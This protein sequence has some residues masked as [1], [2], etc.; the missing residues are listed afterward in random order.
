MKQNYL[1]YYELLGVD[2]SATT[3]QINSAYKQKAKESHPDKND[4]HH[5]AKTLFQYYSEAKEVLTD[6][7]KRLEYD[8]LIGI[9]KRP[10]PRPSIVQTNHSNGS[11]ALLAAG[12]IGLLVGIFLASDSNK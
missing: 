9:K 8:Y 2:Q 11:G 10:E 5:T 1:S 3:E 6:S 7:K 12:A 4:G